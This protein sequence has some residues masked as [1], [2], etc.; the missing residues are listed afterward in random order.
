MTIGEFARRSR[1]PASTLRYYHERGLLVPARVDDTTGYRFYDREQLGTAAIVHRLRG[2]GVAPATIRAIVDG[3][4]DPATAIETERHRIEAEI[5]R[6]TEALARLAR[7][8]RQ[9]VAPPTYTVT[10]EDRPALTAAVVHG[11]VRCSAAASDLRAL[12]IEL[13]RAHRVAGLDDPVGYGA[14]FPLDLE[15]DPMPAAV[16]ARPGNGARP[17]GVTLELPAGRFLVTTH[18][19][20]DAVEPA[21]GALL[22]RAQADGLRPDGAV[23][24]EYEG[25]RDAPSTRVALGVLG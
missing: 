22:D 21:Y 15:T 10:V 3:T 11:G 20:D 7:L 14:V 12:M 8:E 13:R 17:P 23:V 18:R 19:G 4:T 6:R 5:T 24:E 25:T 9:L 16:F 1:L 2:I